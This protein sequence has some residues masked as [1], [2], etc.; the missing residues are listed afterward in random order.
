[1]PTIVTKNSST[2]SDVP[3]SSDLVQGE[4][5]VNVTDKRLF[6]ENASATVVEIGTNPTSVTTGALSSTGITCSGT[7]NGTV[8]TATTNFAGNITGNLTGNSAG[9]HT[10]A[11]TGDVAGNITGTGSSSLTTL[12]T[13][14]LT[15][16]G[17]AY[18]TADGAASTVLGTN[19]SGTLDF[20]SVAGAYDL[21][22]QSEAEAGT[23]TTGK[24]FSPLRVKQAI[25]AL[26]SVN[27]A[28][29]GTIG[30][31]TPNTGAFTNL[32][33][34]GTFTLGGS[35][36]TSTAAELNILDGVTSTAAE[37]N[38][39]D[40][41]T[42]TTAE[43]NYV[44]GVTS[45]IQT[46]IDSISPSPTYEAT[47]SGTIANGD[48]VIVNADGTVSA[49]SGTGASAS[50]G[51]DNIF[52]SGSTSN[53]DSA[54]DESTDRLVVIYRGSALYA[55]VGQINTDGTITFGS[56]A[57][58]AAGASIGSIC[59]DASTSRMLICYKLASD[60]YGYGAVGTVTGAS[61]NSIAIGT[62]AAFWNS[63]AIESANIG[64]AYYASATASVVAFH[65]DYG[66]Y[67]GL[68]RLATITGGGTNTVAFG[69]EITMNSGRARW[70]ERGLFYDPDTERVVACYMDWNESENGYARIINNTTGTTLQAETE[71]EFN[72]NDVEYVAACYDTAN[73]KGFVCY[74]D[75]GDS[76]YLNARVITIV[77]GVTNSLTYGTEVTVASTDV[78]YIDCTFDATAGKIVVIYEDNTANKSY[79]NT[80][81]ISGTGASA[82]TTWDGAVEVVGSTGLA[83]SS[84]IYDPDDGRSV[85][86]Y[87]DSS[88][89][90]YGTTNVYTV[91]YGSTNLTSE[92]Y[93]GISDGAY[94]SSATATIQVAG[95]VDDAQSSLTPGQTYY[96]SFDGSLVLTPVEPSVTAGT[97]VAATKLIVKG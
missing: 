62:A 71:Y 38:I 41:V 95:A 92:N 34:S 81:T 66:A 51:A 11:V 47:A 17:L 76:N 82:T 94:S 44:D 36:V 53:V 40:G 4:L 7:V 32:S 37:L 26:G 8:I 27:W 10:G 60:T 48:T 89:S 23:V 21:A 83:S 84:I 6:T 22:T 33:A 18:P 46:Q 5:A 79:V 61:T 56:Q 96:I 14:N 50:V 31:T 24:I 25:D 54:Y 77:G 20:I 78:S 30:S 86:S 15:A 55:Q 35:A 68:A 80:G 43:L 90:G 97:A 69:S 64:L 49:V 87:E 3:S 29:P 1:M 73:D 67:N 58:V 91:P 85:F 13:T 63:G 93:I 74:K 75:K 70:L 59:Y 39:L 88:N 72:G 57:T 52:N 16:G 2:A 9:T 42:A 45:A 28:V 19:G 12:A 65:I